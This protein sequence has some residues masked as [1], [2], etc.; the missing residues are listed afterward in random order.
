M[1]WERKEI[2]MK[3]V[4]KMFCLLLVLVLVGGTVLP[5][6]SAK[7]EDGIMNH[8][9]KEIRAVATQPLYENKDM[10]TA[11]RNEEIYWK[12]YNPSASKPRITI[13]EQD[14]TEVVYE[15]LNEIQMQYG[16]GVGFMTDQSDTNQWTLGKHEV[17]MNF[18]GQSCTFEVE[19]QENPIKHIEA[20]YQGFLVE[21][22]NATLD[23]YKMEFIITFA[24]GVTDN[25]YIYEDVLGDPIA[26]NFEP[27]TP[28]D[29][30]VPAGKQY[31]K[32]FVCGQEVIMEVDVLDESNNPIQAI[33]AVATNDLVASWHWGRDFQEDKDILQ[34]M[35]S[36]PQITITYRDGSQVTMSYRELESKFPEAEPIL[37]LDNDSLEGIGKRTATLEFYGRTC[38]FDVNVIENPVDRI[39][40]VATK[41]LVEGFRHDMYDLTFDGGVIITVYYKDGRTFSGTV[42]EMNALFYAYPSEEHIDVVIGKNT[43]EYTFLDKTCDVEFEVVPNTNPVVSIEAKI[44]DDA[45]IYK[46]QDALY[47]DLYAYDHLIDVVLTY[48][49]GT[50]L[51]GSIAEVNEQ[52]DKKMKDIAEIWVQ[53]N[54]MQEAWGLGKHE[55]FVTYREMSVPIEVEVVENPYVKATISNEGGFTVIMEKKDGQIETYKAKKYIEAGQTGNNWNILGYLE[56]DKGTLPIETKFVGG[57]RK[58]YT[59]IFYM[60]INGVPSNSL[61]DCQWL[62]QQVITKVTGEVPTVML[63][64]TE[65]ELKDLVLT[66]TD[67]RQLNVDEVEVWLEVGDKKDNISQEE[68]TLLD[69]ATSQLSG[70]ENGMIVDFTVYKEFR[71]SGGLSVTEKVPNLKGNISITVEVPE[72]VLALTT[73]PST[74]SMIRIHNGETQVLPCVFDANAKTITFETDRFST[75][76]MVYHTSSL[77]GGTSLG[78][79]GTSGDGITPSETAPSGTTSSETTAGTTGAQ[80]TD[81]KD[82]KPQDNV[83]EHPAQP[84]PKTGDNN[85]VFIYMLLCVISF[86]TLVVK[87]K[88]EF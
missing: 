25:F 56:T 43:K 74:I 29:Q 45:V 53:D 16:A 28:N 80:S 81:V 42:D 68:Q 41:P 30:S 72:E 59:K 71:N 12:E 40:V 85:R 11:S 3:R 37:T 31:F 50:K 60:Y 52:L 46:N 86:M 70:Y 39:S 77:S 82:S 66:E 8:S 75:Y 18:M 22:S 9:I 10:V 34:A 4:K 33:S 27:Y 24:N 21:G 88:K 19:L 14:G 26:P 5:N 23:Q 69:E 73:D 64:H 83:T 78:G 35:Y 49:D 57:L 47:R 76:A 67:Y 1:L 48:K 38:T 55:A 63:N 13:V 2:A 6:I 17:T 36:K 61:E 58:D 15:D 7:A 79:G 54:Q 32:G 87:K 62:E 84:S 51:T 20:K 65:Q 44:Q